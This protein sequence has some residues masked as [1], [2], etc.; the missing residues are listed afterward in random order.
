M[1]IFS[2]HDWPPRQYHWWHSKNVCVHL[3]PVTHRVIN[4]P[5]NGTPFT[6]GKQTEAAN[7]C[8]SKCGP[9]AS[10]TGT[11]SI[12]KNRFLSPNAYLLLQKHNGFTV[13]FFCW[14]RFKDSDVRL[15]QW[16][17][18]WSSSPYLLLSLNPFEGYVRTKWFALSSLRCKELKCVFQ[19]VEGLKDLEAFFNIGKD[20]LIYR[21]WQ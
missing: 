13:W 9:W 8:F 21:C 6:E 4:R 2:F 16:I 14:V 17:L 3:T 7:S 1:C 12:E 10:C 11:T 5:V 18:H 20:K 19:H 15:W